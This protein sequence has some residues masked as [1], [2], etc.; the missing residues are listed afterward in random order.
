MKSGHLDRL[1]LRTDKATANKGRKMDLDLNYKETIDFI[2]N[3]NEKNLSHNNSEAHKRAARKILIDMIKSLSF[4]ADET[5]FYS[6]TENKDGSVSIGEFF[7]YEDMKYSSD[8]I[9]AYME[10]K[11]L[12]DRLNTPAGTPDKKQ[13]AETTEADGFEDVKKKYFSG[14]GSKGG[15]KDKK[16]KVLKKFVEDYHLRN[17]DADFKTAW[18]AWKKYTEY[19]PYSE[20]GNEIYFTDELCFVNGKSYSK[21]TVRRYFTAIKKDCRKDAY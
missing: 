2:I 12:M 15:R 9:R 11:S 17:L 16:N 1:P 21:Q 5:G 20:K 4:V 19:R 10:N 13:P 7:R 18:K 3:H 14:I 6:Y 8:G